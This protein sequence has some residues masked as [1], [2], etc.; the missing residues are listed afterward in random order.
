M[1]ERQQ[2]IIAQ[3]IFM[4]FYYDNKHLVKQ[5]KKLPHHIVIEC[6]TLR[7]TNQN[8]TPV[9]TYSLTGFGMSLD[10]VKYTYPH[11]TASFYD[12]WTLAAAAKWAALP[13]CC[14][15]PNYK[16]MHQPQKTPANKPS[17]TGLGMSLIQIK[18]IFPCQQAFTMT[19]ALAQ[20]AKNAAHQ[21]WCCCWV[22]PKS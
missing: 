2:E 1:T 21:P 16:N 4:S 11:L 5:P 19:E 18:Y 17:L 9:N 13:H 8:K 15:V 6:K 3:L 14:W 20:G 10:Q 12:D 7:C 22:M